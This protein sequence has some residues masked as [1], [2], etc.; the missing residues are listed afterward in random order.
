MLLPIFDHHPDR[1]QMLIRLTGIMQQADR[2]SEQ[3]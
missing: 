3:A 1:M 2:G